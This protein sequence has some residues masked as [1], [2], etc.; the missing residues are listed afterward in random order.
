MNNFVLCSSGVAPGVDCFGAAQPA[1][2]YDSP[3]WGGFR[4]ETSVGTADVVPAILDVDA[5]STNNDLFFTHPS[6]DDSHFWDFALFYTADWNSIK[7]SLAGAYTWLESNPLNGGEEQYYQAGGSIL[8]KPSGLGIYAMGS[9]ED[10]GDDK[11]NCL[12]VLGGNCLNSLSFTALPDTDMWGVKPFWRKNWGSANGVG[13]G[14]VGATTFYA[15]YAQY[16]DM[17]GLGAINNVQ[18]AFPVCDTPPFCAITGSEAERWGLGVVQE[19]DSAA[20]HV[21]LRWQHQTLDVDII[22]F[23]GDHRSQSFEDQDLFQAGGIIFF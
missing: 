18:I 11:N 17:Y 8:H 7:I 13:L 16:N 2:R 20:M 15:E 19:I 4:F 14:Q 6:T 1:V 21:W 9:W 12:G 22:N 23:F 10:V 3:T 5:A